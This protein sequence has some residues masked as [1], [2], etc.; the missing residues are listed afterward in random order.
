MNYLENVTRISQIITISNKIHQ[1][2]QSLL[3]GF[4]LYLQKMNSSKQTQK[5]TLCQQELKECNINAKVGFDEVLSM[6]GNF[7]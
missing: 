2:P 1:K 3:H 7:I 5:S 4:Q 6:Q